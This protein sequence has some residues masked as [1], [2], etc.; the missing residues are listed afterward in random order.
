MIHP[1]NLHSFTFHAKESCFISLSSSRWS[2]GSL[3][4]RKYMALA[5]FELYF[6][7]P[8]L[9]AFM[10]W[11]SMDCSSY[12]ALFTTILLSL[13]L[14]DVPVPVRL[15]LLCE[16]HGGKWL[17]AFKAFVALSPCP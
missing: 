7:F 14:V 15:L 13:W 1:F 2:Y 9:E 10:F 6:C 5:F 12:S 17:T 4:F 11:M 16:L 8:P 3:R